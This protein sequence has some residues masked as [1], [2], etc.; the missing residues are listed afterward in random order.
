LQ[1]HLKKYVVLL[2]ATCGTTAKRPR[3]KRKIPSEYLSGL[4]AE[5][6]FVALPLSHKLL[7]ADTFKNSALK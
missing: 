7:K 5:D 3:K 1:I 4:P 6:R 2:C